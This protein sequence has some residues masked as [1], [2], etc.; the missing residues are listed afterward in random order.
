[1]TMTE[2]FV[3]QSRVVP[4]DGSKP[5]EW[6]TGR[7]CKTREEADADVANHR[8]LAEKVPLPWMQYRSR[9]ILVH[10]FY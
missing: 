1:M 2:H 6:R 10:S 8:R 4:V 7:E 5:S 9:R 3:V